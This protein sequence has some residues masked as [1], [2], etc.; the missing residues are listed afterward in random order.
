MVAV[1]TS[2]WPRYGRTCSNYC[3]SFG[4]ACVATHHIADYGLNFD[5]GTCSIERTSPCDEY[6]YQSPVCECSIDADVFV[7]PEDGVFY[8]Y[9]AIGPGFETNHALLQRIVDGEIRKF[10]GG[11]EIREVSDEQTMQ[12]VVQAMK[13]LVEVDSI[14]IDNSG[15]Q[16]LSFDSLTKVNSCCSFRIRCA[17]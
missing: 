4:K 13:K 3:Q 17:L 2:M 5:T 12:L 10:R 1:N 6:V 11:I 7:S 16:T 14:T 9:L 15:F 8:G